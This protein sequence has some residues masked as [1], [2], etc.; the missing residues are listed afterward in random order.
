MSRFA[1]DLK[2]W[3]E[4]ATQNLAKSSD[5]KAA[6]L[7]M[8]DIPS[9]LK[10]TIRYLREQVPMTVERFKMECDRIKDLR[11]VF[12]KIDD[13]KT[14]IKEL[15]TPDKNVIW[16]NKQRR[17]LETNLE[18]LNNDKR[19][20]TRQNA[21]QKEKIQQLEV[22]N[23]KFI[24]SYKEFLKQKEILVNAS[25]GLETAK[26]KLGEQLKISQ[27]DN[28]KSKTHN[29]TLRE[30]IA[31]LEQKQANLERDLAD[32][33]V[34]YK[35]EIKLREECQMKIASLEKTNAELLSQLEIII[36][37]NRELQ[38]GMREWRIQNQDIFS[39]LKTLYR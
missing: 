1:P 7:S 31:I 25:T 26:T 21:A 23:Q 11:M 27:E 36:S 22:M 29:D 34:L 33:K 37:A 17:D 38:Q 2:P 15:N 12:N 24:G 10:N 30:A 6:D 35:E 8:E 19:T 5:M 3:I 16:L 14:E 9:E 20:L 28:A 39:Q 32:T 4:I 18:D 13:L